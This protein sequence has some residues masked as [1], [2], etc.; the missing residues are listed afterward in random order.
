MKTIKFPQIDIPVIGEYDV[1]IV[2]G[3]TS[4]AF[5]GIAAAREGLKTLIIEQLGCLGGSATAGLVMPLMS[6]YIKD[7]D[8]N[9]PI[10]I[11]VLERLRDIDA[12]YSDNIQF[13]DTAMLK[14]VLEDLVSESGADLL[15][16]TSI[17]SVIVKDEKITHIIVNNKDG[18]K[19]FA[20]EYVIDATGD[21]DIAVMAGVPFES[22]KVDKIN[23]P[24][25][26]RFEMGGIQFDEFHAFMQKLGNSSVK[27]FAMN[28]P[29]M[30][31]LLNKA[32][33]DGVLTRQDI[34]Y[35]QAFGIPGRPDGMAF[36]C[37]ELLPKENIIDA[38]F[39]TKKQVE[40]KKAILRLRKFL[41]E[42][43]PGFQNAYI[44]EIAG[45]L[46][47]R[48]SRRIH[49]EYIMTIH[50][51]LM[52]K[53]F[54]DAVTQSA[55]PLD[56]HGKDNQME[57]LMGYDK[58]TPENERYWEVPFRVMIPLKIQNML[59]TGRCAGFDFLTQSAT[60]IQPI[61]RAMGEA[62][63]IGTAFAF[64]EKKAFKDIDFSWIKNRMIK[65]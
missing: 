24:L 52:Y 19:G 28:T 63:G 12:A 33:E 8:G 23:Q 31:E 45:M 61:C 35:F 20:A 30:K 43:I 55:Y 47:I 5:A 3:G 62:A 64:K 36:N 11:E 57:G 17:I 59:V 54:N 32:K 41:R 6:S 27:Y 1:I 2:G 22:G 37:P 48:E 13:F 34:T 49:S 15:Y 10:G 44:T 50:D 16:H 53:K 21:A 4:G 7:K 9:C 25:S 18:L 14:I 56:V 39:L 38:A 26:L 65:N 60:R 46:G 42:Y 29:G 51:I 58:T 40:G